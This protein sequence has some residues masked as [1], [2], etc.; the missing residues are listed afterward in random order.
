MAKGAVD[1]DACPSRTPKLRRCRC[2]KCDVCGQPKH[3]AVHGPSFGDPPGSKPWGHEYV[4][5][6][7]SPASEGVD[8]QE[9]A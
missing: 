3:S 6:A 2:E 1:L 7:L 5:P 4:P 9:G 8:S